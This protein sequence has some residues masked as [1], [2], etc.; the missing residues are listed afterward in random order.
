MTAAF[1]DSGGEH[2]PALGEP[3]AP[4]AE[5]I[6]KRELWR[7]WMLVLFLGALTA[8]VLV[9]LVLHQ[10]FQLGVIEAAGL[11]HQGQSPRGSIV[12]RLGALLAADRYFYEVSTTPAHFDDEEARAEGRRR[13][14]EAGGHPQERDPAPVAG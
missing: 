3:T 1:P 9:P 8:A 11:P 2:P 14:G 10:A 4:P 12:D 13:P 6:Q 7:F 5:S